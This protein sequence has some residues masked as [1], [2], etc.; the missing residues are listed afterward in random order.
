VLR[1]DFKVVSGQIEKECIA[2]EPTLEKYLAIVH[3]M[4]SYFKGFT[5]EYIGRNKNVEDNNLVK[6]TASNAPLPTDVLSMSL[7]MPPSKQFCQSPDSSISLRE[8]T[9]EP[10]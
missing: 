2:R 9:G 8:R 4:E 1:T 5:V 6:A 10:R 3:R 7:K